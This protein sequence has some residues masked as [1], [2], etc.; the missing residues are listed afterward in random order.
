M[1]MAIVLGALLLVDVAVLA[2]GLNRFHHK[3]VS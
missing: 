3:A 2:A 1:N